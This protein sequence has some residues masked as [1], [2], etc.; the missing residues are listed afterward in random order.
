MH[1]GNASDELTG[2]AVI[3]GF[4]CKVAD[5]FLTTAA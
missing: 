2:E 3:P 4:R 5:L 1:D